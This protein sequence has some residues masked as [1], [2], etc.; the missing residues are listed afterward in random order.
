MLILT[1]KPGESLYIGDTVK[2]TIVEIKGNQ[3]RVGIDAPPELRIYREEIYLQIL[4]E[5]KSAAEAAL[6]VE[7]LEPGFAAPK[8]MQP[9]AKMPK[10]S[11]AG[12]FSSA[13]VSDPHIVLKK[14]KR[15]PDGSVG[16]EGS[17]DL[18]G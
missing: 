6:S 13:K 7:G 12:A 4:E 14:R 5:N 18:D 15:K 17:D 3:I 1:R 9:M 2:V 11:G 10:S 8:A 16:G